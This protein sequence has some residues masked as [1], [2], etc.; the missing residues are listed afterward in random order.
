[1]FYVIYAEDKENSLAARKS[2]RPAHLERLLALKEQG[3]LLVS[4][5]TPA[6]E[7]EDPGEAGFT[8]SVIIA[9][10]ASQ[11]DAEQWA[12]QDPYVAAGV[13]EKVTIKPFKYVLP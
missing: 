3:R 9:E 2:A 13:Y 6:I 7:A 4:G 5:P 10:F 12:E 1:M 8:G 11:S